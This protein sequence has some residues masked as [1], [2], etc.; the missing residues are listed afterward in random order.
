MILKTFNKRIN[1]DI[2]NGIKNLKKLFMKI[3]YLQIRLKGADVKKTDKQIDTKEV[4][5]YEKNYESSSY[6]KKVKDPSF[7]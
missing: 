7:K 4:S 1:W 5:N 6:W 2:L 3:Y